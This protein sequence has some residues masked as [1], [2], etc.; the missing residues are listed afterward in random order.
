MSNLDTQSKLRKGMHHFAVSRPILPICVDI[1]FG[2]PGKDCQ[3]AGICQM[4]PAE[5]VRVHW[6]C[7]NARAWMYFTVNGELCLMFE[8]QSLA[9]EYAERYF[10]NAFFLVEEAYSI[11]KA[12]LAPFN[13]ADFRVESGLYSVEVSDNF[14]RIFL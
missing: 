6:K 5:H 2:S 14:Y 12:L 1:V 7:P 11:P 3:G 9:P 8:R 4:I 10:K 13:R